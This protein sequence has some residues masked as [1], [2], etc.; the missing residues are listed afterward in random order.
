V[1]ELARRAVNEAGLVHVA[2]VLAGYNNGPVLDTNAVFDA[3]F[4]DS[5][6]ADH[7]AGKPGEALVTPGRGTGDH[8]RII[9]AVFVHDCCPP[10]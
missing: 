9:Q 1:R 3:A 2:Q 10:S 6:S 5:G 4:R 7:L 8:Y